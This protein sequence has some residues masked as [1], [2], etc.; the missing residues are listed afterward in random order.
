MVVSKLEDLDKAYGDDLSTTLRAA[1]TAS[2]KQGLSV[3]ERHADDEGSTFQPATND[4]LQFAFSER[5]A[6]KQPNLSAVYLR[7]WEME[8][9]DISYQ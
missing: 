3:Q 7:W 9:C 2:I 5:F 1:W 8:E 6:N 4:P